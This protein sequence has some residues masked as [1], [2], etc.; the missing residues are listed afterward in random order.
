VN[1]GSNSNACSLLSLLSEEL[2][3][4]LIRIARLAELDQHANCAKEV[5]ASTQSALA[6]IDAYSIGLNTQQQLDLEPVGASAVLHDAAH[7]L[8]K[9]QSVFDA[10]VR[11]DIKGRCKPVMV[12]K[13]AFK[14]VITLIG[15]MF[16]Q[17]PSDS[18]SQ[19]ITL[20]MHNSKHGIIAGV[21]ADVAADQFASLRIPNLLTGHARQILPGTIHGSGANVV[22]ANSIARL[23]DSTV[24]KSRHSNQN[25]Y[26]MTLRTSSQV[27]LV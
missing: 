27:Q 1:D 15:Q 14:H 3:Q 5:I 16:M 26:G 23:F 10:K 21:Y 7:E 25:G 18:A 9:Y 11:L 19:V 17:L 13:S 2:K 12:N 20:G 4:P 24:K 22:L 6:L 8:S